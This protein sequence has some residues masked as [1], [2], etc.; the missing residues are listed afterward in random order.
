MKSMPF[1]LL[2][3]L[4][5]HASLA[6]VQPA[7]DRAN[8]PAQRNAELE[9]RVLARR[10][11]IAEWFRPDFRRRL[12]ISAD[13]IVARIRHGLLDEDFASVA[14][15]EAQ[16]KTRTKLTPV[17]AD[18][19][20]FYVLAQTTRRLQAEATAETD[21]L[22]ALARMESDRLRKALDGSSTLMS[23]LGNM[24]KKVADAQASVVANVK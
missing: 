2:A 19:L 4:P 11:E 12:D 1:V 14:R 20:A 13:G 9:Q 8:V 7:G 24:L 3:L 21:S 23:A 5:F 22:P 6:Q 18:V 16:Q 17:Q 15:R 10:S